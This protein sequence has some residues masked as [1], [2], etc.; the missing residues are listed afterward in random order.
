MNV[1]CVREKMKEE[2]WVY[3]FENPRALGWQQ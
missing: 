1:K 3:L 2:T